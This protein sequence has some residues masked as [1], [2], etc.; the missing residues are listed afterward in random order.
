MISE[1]KTTYDG[2]GRLSRG[3]DSGQHPAII[4]QDQVAFAVNCTFR[5]GF[6]KTRPGLNPV[7]LTG[8]DFQLGRWQ[9]AH[10]YQDSSGAGTVIASI[11]GQIVRFDPFGHSVTNLS[12]VSGQT[13]PTNRPQ[14]WM[15]QAETFLPIQDGQSVPLIWDGSSLYRAQ[16]VALGGTQLPVGCMMEYQRG[17]LW[18]V[19]EE[20]KTFA[21]GDLAYSMTGNAS[22]L[23]NFTENQFLAGGGEFS[24]PADVGTINGIKSVS[25]QD[26]V[27][28]Q[29][30]LEIFAERG[31]ASI[32][33]PFDRLAWQ[34]TQSPIQV[35][36]LLSSGPVAQ[37]AITGVNGDLW[38]RSTDG[39]RSFMIARRDQGTWVNTPLSHEMDRIFSMDDP[40]LMDHCSSARFDNRLLVTCSPY[41]ALSVADDVVTEYGTA[42]RGLAVLDFQSVSSMFDRTQP[43]WEGMW[44]GL[45]ILEIV[46][47]TNYGI[48]HCFLFTL[49]SD[50]EIEMW[51]LSLADPFDNRNVRIESIIETKRFGSVD[52]AEALKQFVRPEMWL[53]NL[54][55]EVLFELQYRPDA[56]RGWLAVDSG[57]TCATTGICEL[58][59][60]TPPVFPN[61][62]YRPRLIGSAPSATECEAAVN[63]P[64]R[65]GFEFQFRFTMTGRWLLRRYRAAMAEVPE[66]LGPGCFGETACATESGC[67]EDPF[68]YHLSE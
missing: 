50:N 22:D 47:V 44:T 17:R 49:N 42:W 54:M 65:N 20:R 27:T 5:G 63:K 66:K 33:A 59:E 14:A 68:A 36:S 11:G 61:D 18:V 21:A 48:E 26:S 51:E 37:A 60:C 57:A 46:R 28:G 13:N 29:G 8:D 16:P 58:T 25:N 55:G 43:V 64:Y 52:L 38:Y 10:A 35:I 62:Q 7:T 9:G 53:E 32:D 31:A 19:L 34:T 3:M 4:G 23:L 40:N 67:E 56:F 15:V 1:S 2:F 12:A 30:A 45:N 39:V 6:V 41:R 24:I